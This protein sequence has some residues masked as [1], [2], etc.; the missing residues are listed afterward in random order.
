MNYENAVFRKCT[1]WLKVVEV[2]G[3]SSQTEC[4]PGMYVGGLGLDPRYCKR[5][6]QTCSGW[7]ACTFLKGRKK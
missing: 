1:T 3:Y 2:K 4:L 6:D 5:Q 7:K